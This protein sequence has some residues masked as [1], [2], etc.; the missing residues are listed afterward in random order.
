MS[1]QRKLGSQEFASDFA[2]RATE[3][4]L[5]D[6]ILLI[7]RQR[8]GVPLCDVGGRWGVPLSGWKK[9]GGPSTQ[10][11]DTPHFP[12]T[13]SYSVGFLLLG[14]LGIKDLEQLLA[15]LSVGLISVTHLNSK[16]FPGDMEVMGELRVPA[17]N[18]SKT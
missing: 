9:G 6:M 13:S 14:E 5:R 18:E 17:N 15:H 1:S 16:V 7:R 12:S 2:R 10:Q 3:F 8:G 4:I 11:R